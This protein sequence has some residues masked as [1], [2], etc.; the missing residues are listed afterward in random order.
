VND[1][2]ER[3]ASDDDGAGS[4]MDLDV[5]SLTEDKVVAVDHPL[6]YKVEV[7]EDHFPY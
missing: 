4:R 1:V 2:D 5:V 6:D 3:Y 7:E